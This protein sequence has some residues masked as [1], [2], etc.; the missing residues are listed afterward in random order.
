[1]YRQIETN[2]NADELAFI[3]KHLFITSAL[4][5]VI[6]ALDPISEHRLDFMAKLKIDGKSLKQFWRNSY[7]QAISSDE[8]IVSLLSSEFEAIFSPKFQKTFITIA[9]MEE[10]NGRSQT[11]STISKKARGKMI[12]WA[13][14]EKVGKVDKI[15]QFSEEGYQFS[16]ALSTEQKLVFVK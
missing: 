9:F 15:K 12:N 4:Y 5:G 7:D 2:F 6:N 11:H 10:K 13:I 14:Q 8:V 1:M 16:E 3:K